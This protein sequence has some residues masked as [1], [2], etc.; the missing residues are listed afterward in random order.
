M[1]GLL[2]SVLL[3]SSLAYLFILLYMYVQQRSLQY[4]PSHQ[5]IPPEALSLTGVS[6]DKKTGKWRATIQVKGKSK[7]L[8]SYTEY[9]DAALA[10]DARARP[11]GRRKN[12][13]K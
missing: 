8:G 12:F 5:G 7:N 4:F 11:L 10:Y 1:M 9:A 6:E 13:K 2:R 3:V